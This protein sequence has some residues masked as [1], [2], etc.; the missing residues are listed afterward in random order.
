MSHLF[1]V[2]PGHCS[3]PAFPLSLTLHFL[4]SQSYRDVLS[5]W[6]ESQLPDLISSC[7]H[8]ISLARSPHCR[9]EKAFLAW[10]GFDGSWVIK[11]EVFHTDR[12]TSYQVLGHNTFESLCFYFTDMSVLPVW[13]LCACL[14]IEEAR[15]GHPIPWNWSYT[16]LWVTTWVLGNEPRSSASVLNCWDIPSGP[17]L[18]VI[19]CFLFVSFWDGVLL[20]IPGWPR[21]S[22]CNPPWP[23]AHNSPP[24]SA[25]WMLG[26]QASP[27][28]PKWKSFLINY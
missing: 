13:T 10:M 9:R 25:I 22:P 28:M 24:T 11:R 23:Q 8:I 5:C 3:L 6:W 2:H 7:K 15:K 14:V 4:L 20:C 19:S 27:T 12:C 21:P 16:Q 18:N 26:L 1:S 17:I